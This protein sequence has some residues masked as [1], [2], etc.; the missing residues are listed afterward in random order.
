MLSKA[1]FLPGQRASV[2]QSFQRWLR[3]RVPPQKSITLNQRCIFIFPTK[4]GFAFAALLILLFLGAINYENSLI[5]ALTFLLASL[6]HV[7]IYS[8]FRNLSG[9]S[10]E[11]VSAKR[12][13]VGEDIE[14][15]VRLS[16][17]REASREGIALSWR[18]GTKQ[19]IN[20]EA[21]SAATVR[22]FATAKRRGWMQPG[23]LLVETVFPLGLLRAW[24]WLDLDTQALVYPKPLFDHEPLSVVNAEEE[25]EVQ[26]RD[27][28]EEWHDLRTY[29]TGDPLKHV[30]WRSYARGGDLML[31]KFS[32]PLGNEVIFDW[33]RIAGDTELRIS[34]LTG[35]VLDAS[36]GEQVYGLRL[37]GVEIHLDSGQAHRDRVLTELALYA[38]A[39]D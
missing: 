8:T 1:G 36:Q 15:V 12:G 6:F 14:F 16:H 25:G 38:L 2:Q 32:D 30:A 21:S 39:T 10:L 18:E 27:G 26:Q 37:P 28:G 19:W 7:A 24:S 13:F 33:D 31:K 5:H 29:Q 23:R 11:C 20:L 22:V 3:R 17:E 34:R 4:I 35:L 9:L